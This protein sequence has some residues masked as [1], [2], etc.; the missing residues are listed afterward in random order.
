V[1]RQLPR[2]T[3]VHAVEETVDAFTIDGQT[4]RWYRITQFVEG[5]I[6]GAWLESVQ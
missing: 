3:A 5:W 1:I 2:G 6:F 4:A